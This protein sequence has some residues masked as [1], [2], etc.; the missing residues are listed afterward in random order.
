MK[1]KTVCLLAWLALGVGMSAA[2][3][4]E[5]PSG[6]HGGGWASGRK[7][8]MEALDKDG[9]G[10]VSDEEKAVAREAWRARREAWRKE[11]L[12][13]HDQDGDGQIS[14]EERA[15]AWQARRAEMR[16]KMF[17]ELDLDG[18]G[19]VSGAE[20]AERLERMTEAWGTLSKGESRLTDEEKDAM[21]ESVARWIDEMVAR[22]DAD[23]DGRVSEAEVETGMEAARAR[24]AEKCRAHGAAGGKDE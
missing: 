2:E 11:H 14:Q 22:F 10:Q 23:G 24:W 19:Q 5:P 6:G 1:T 17:A 21:S 15:A 16:K 3:S 18:D 7:R 4:P 12:A 13:K 9:D 20:I 8:M